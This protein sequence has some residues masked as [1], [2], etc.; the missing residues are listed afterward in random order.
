MKIPGDGL[1]VSTFHMPKDAGV[2][3]NAPWKKDTK[4]ATFHMKVFFIP[5][6]SSS[7]YSSFSRLFFLL[8]VSLFIL[9]LFRE[10]RRRDGFP[11]GS[12]SATSTAQ[13]SSRPSRSGFTWLISTCAT[14]LIASERVKM[15]CYY[16]MVFLSPPLYL[17]LPSALSPL[18][19]P[20]SPH[21]KNKRLIFS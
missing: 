14:P 3:R 18:P 21:P 9:L 17:P 5:V 19:S 6:C 10:T 1:S 15:L 20:L 12:N 13:G 4:T 16:S 7:P 11:C 8:F 2:N